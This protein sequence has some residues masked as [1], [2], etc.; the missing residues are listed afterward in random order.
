VNALLPGG[1]TLTGKIPPS[2]DAA[3]KAKLLEPSVVVPPLLW[4]AS[5]ASNG[6]TGMR[7]NAS[8]WRAEVAR[9][10]AALGLD[11]LCARISASA[12]TP[13]GF[14]VRAGT[15]GGFPCPLRSTI[16]PLRGPGALGRGE[17]AC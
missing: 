11:A 8:L 13:C 10:K 3:L 15:L 14:G 12:D 16:G 1:A 6:V 9:R 5:D 7:F 2:V 17:S 4:L